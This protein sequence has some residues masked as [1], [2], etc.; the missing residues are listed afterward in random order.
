VTLD[1]P[2]WFESREPVIASHP[3]PPGSPARHI[4]S[5]LCLASGCTV[6]LAEGIAADRDEGVH[7][8][9]HP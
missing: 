3:A 7:L 9:S 1:R 6:A 2:A 8:R 4:Q 5:F